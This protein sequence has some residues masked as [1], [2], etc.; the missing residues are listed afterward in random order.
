MN[1]LNFT[2]PIS[3]LIVP[4]PTEPATRGLPGFEAVLNHSCSALSLKK[5]PVKDSI[6]FE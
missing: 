2:P 1:I 4:D 5:M 3:V 6:A